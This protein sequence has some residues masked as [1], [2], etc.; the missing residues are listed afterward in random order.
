MTNATGGDLVTG[1]VVV[2]DPTADRSVIF[3]TKAGDANPL[4]IQIGGADGEVI[5][6]YHPGAGVELITCDGPAVVAGDLIVTSATNKLGKPLIAGEEPE[7]ILGVA[8]EAGTGVLAVM[9]LGIPAAGGGGLIPPLPTAGNWT[10]DAGSGSLSPTT[11]LDKVGI[12][13]AGPDVWLHVS[14]GAAE[15][16]VETPDASDPTL[17]FK[18]TNTAHQVD[19]WLDE[20]AVEDVLGIG[21]TL[22]VDDTN[23]S[24]G[25]GI[26]PA[27][28]LHLVTSHAPGDGGAHFVVEDNGGVMRTQL[29]D[30]GT[31]Q[32]QL[33]SGGM[34]A[35][36]GQIEVDTPGGVPGIVIWTGV[37]GAYI[38]RW[39]FANRGG[40]IDFYW[41]AD[42][43]GS[44]LILE[45]GGNIG[46][47]ITPLTNVHLYEDNADT[48]PALR[49]E[50]DGAGD[51]ATQYLLT[52]GQ[53]FSTGIDNS[54]GDSLVIAA[55][56]NLQTSPWF[57]ISP[58]GVTLIGDV[59]GADYAK[60]ET[61]G[62]LEMNGAAMVFNDLQFAISNAKVPASNAP[63]WETFTA[64]T[65][66]YGFAVD[67][68]ID[69]QANETPHS[70]KLGEPGHVHAHI[71]TKAANA[72]GANRFAKFTI[73]VAYGDMGEAWQESSF[74][75]ELTI[76]DGTAA[77]QQFYL[78][79]GN[80]TLT[81]YVEEA[82]IRCRI[83]RIA[84]T[85]GVEYAGN[86]FITQVGIHL[87]EDTI[88][89]RTELSK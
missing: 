42:G 29:K 69:T 85:G 80:L 56:A 50:Q 22:Y 78:D 76:P 11:I 67:D 10:R 41:N 72:T 35:E 57:N 63:T 37:P 49:I 13:S 61:D 8:M 60:I 70:W 58:A 79:M 82:E 16:R 86:I 48:E 5:K 24:I 64:N 28:P 12:G 40:Y 54:V 53:S 19:V 46:V 3:A 44:S 43:A 83:T 14:A 30:G 25:V 55:G 26:V 52:G 2:V 59:D 89:S 74:T 65:N 33:Y 1:D 4:V 23:T 17:S 9:I 45:A 31:Q 32:W 73:V 87:E 75:A 62:T 47:A 15:I 81:T 39:Q 84:A 51:A 18:T 36:V 20:S 88:G 6:C 7:S 38:N 34:A 66:E 21:T 68:Y 71:T 27:Y 77:L